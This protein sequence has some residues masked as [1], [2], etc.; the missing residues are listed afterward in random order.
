VGAFGIIA[1]R[2]ASRTLYERI[3]IVAP[4]DGKGWWELARLRLAD[5]DFAGARS[6]LTSMLETV[7]DHEQRE[8][9]FAALDAIQT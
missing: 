1:A 6:S 5:G 4:A 3:T 2:Q 7:R 8:A 9:V